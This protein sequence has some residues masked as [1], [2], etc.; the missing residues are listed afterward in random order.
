MLS[1]QQVR[2]PLVGVALSLAAGLAVQR[3]SNGSPLLLLGLSALVLALLCRRQT[4]LRIYACCALLGAAAGSVVRDTP[5]DGHRL[6][7]GNSENVAVAGVITDDPQH[8]PD[9]TRF[10]LKVDAVR[11]NG[12]WRSSRSRLSVYLRP[13]VSAAA[14]GERWLIDGEQTL[15][16]RK[17]SRA[18]GWLRAGGSDAV[19]LR[20]AGFSIKRFCYRLRH[21]ASEL[22]QEGLKDNPSAAGLLQAMLLGYRRSIP[23][24]LY[25]IFAG[26]GTLHIFAIS[27]LHVGV[28]ATLLIAILKTAG[29]A[30]P[31]WGAWLIPAL[32]IYVVATGMKPSALRA[33]TMAA[34]YFAAPLTGRRPDAPSSIALAAILLLAIHPLQIEEPGFL[35][36]FTVV[37]GIVM[38]HGFV[39]RRVNGLRRTGW[40]GPLR[41]LAGDHPLAGLMRAT[42]LLLITSLAAGL[43]SAP[44]TA[45]F[46]NTLSPVALLCNPAM[47]PLTFFIVMTGC[48]TLFSGAAGLL[49]LTTLFSQANGL[50]IGLLI[51][52]IRQVGGW[53]GAWRFV[54]SPALPVMGLWYGGVV[55]IF[56]GTPRMRKAGAAAAA[57][58]VLLWAS[59]GIPGR[60]QIELFHA[61]D[62]ASLLR[63]PQNRWV[64]TTDGNPF[65]AFKTESLLKRQGVNRLHTLAVSDTRADPEMIDR[66]RRLFRPQEFEPPEQTGKRPAFPVREGRIRLFSERR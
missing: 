51:G 57:A 52:L 60:S 35:L 33:F 24:D 64:L 3:M 61:G 49:P 11:R 40:T 18:D 14:C 8:L 13:P 32:W 54:R 12:Q 22:L 7:A 31:R 44:L 42:G 25:R 39:S 27:G 16:P 36:S 47:I 48:L 6:S 37:S 38:V 46:F 43:F 19:R 29:V 5:P 50:F 30:R 66:L 20:P 34:V 26:T 63:L 17:R 45:R 15:Y 65:H 1:A 10:T 41:Q 62:S 53:P 59:Q 56:S 28:M 9:Q 4:A 21:R 55:L 2:R 58:G 23:P